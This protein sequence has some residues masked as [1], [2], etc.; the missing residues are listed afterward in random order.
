MGDGAEAA[1]LDEDGLFVEHLA[2]LEDRA[3]GAE[4]GRAAEAELDE[5]EGHEAV[6]HVA[7]FDAFEVDEV[8]LDAAR[9]QLVEQALHELLR[10]VMEEEGTVE[11]VHADDAQGLLLE[12]GLG[13]L[14]AD[15]DDDLA[16]LVVRVGLEFDAHPAVAFV[17]A[18]VA[19]RDDRV[20]E[21]RRTPWSRRGSR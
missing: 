14:H 18:L 8:D 3:V 6:V 11:Q 10:L 12:G 9:R 4:H 16:R 20:G 15:V 7:E 2:G 1:A 19:A 13:V 5:F 21:R 17:A